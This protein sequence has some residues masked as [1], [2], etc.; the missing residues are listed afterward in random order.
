MEFLLGRKQDGTPELH[1]A[2]Y[3][4]V[5]IN[6]AQTFFQILGDLLWSQYIDP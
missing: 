3:L 4:P 1:A 2:Q 6:P 5:L